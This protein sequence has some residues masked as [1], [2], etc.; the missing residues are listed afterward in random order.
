MVNWSFLTK[1]LIEMIGAS[2]GVV[3]DPKEKSS[4]ILEM[5]VSL[6]MNKD[7][8]VSCDEFIDGCSKDEQLAKLLCIGTPTC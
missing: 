2:T 3:M 8:V 5:F 1:A 4:K 6:D 7:G